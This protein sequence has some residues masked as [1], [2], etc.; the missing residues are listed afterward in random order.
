[1]LVQFTDKEAK[2]LYGGKLERA[3]NGAA[4]F[5]L[6]IA[7]IGGGTIGTGVKVAI[8]KGY[9]GLVLPRSGLGFKY[10]LNLK[11]GTGLIDSDYRGEILA[12]LSLAGGVGV[13]TYKHHI[14]L[15][16]YYERVQL[17]VGD[18]FCQMV[19]VPFYPDASVVDS[20]D[21]TD[22]GEGGIGSTGVI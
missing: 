5:D 7:S 8:P 11:N 17:C 12:R 3:T 22:R 19:V 15:I 1:M 14:E 16:T 21:E 13:E 4:G 20:L 9:A 10:G 6:R 18:R 2:K